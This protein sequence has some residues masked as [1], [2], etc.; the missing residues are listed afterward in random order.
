MLRSAVAFS[1]GTSKRPSTI[2]P[3]P[4]KPPRRKGLPR[5][6]TTAR[7][8]ESG[9]GRPPARGQALLGTGRSVAHRRGHARP[10]PISPLFRPGRGQQPVSRC[11]AGRFSDYL[12]IDYKDLAVDAHRKMIDQRRLEMTR[13]LDEGC[14]QGGLT[15][16]F[17]D[18]YR[19]EITYEW[20]KLVVS[21][22]TN[23]MF[24]NGKRDEGIPAVPAGYYDVLDQVELVD[25][26]AIGT[27][28]Y[29]RFLERNF[30][31]IFFAY[32]KKG[33]ISPTLSRCPL[34]NPRPLQKPTPTTIRPSRP[35]TAKSC[36]SFL[37]GNHRRLP[38]GPF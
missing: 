10:A 15:P 28:H 8:S 3:L 14:A 2:S 7:R 30:S 27:T 1:V 29:R 38:T 13:F 11:P 25:E 20:A 33:G 23:Y 5:G 32:G 35:C 16:A 12:R 19:A 22:P 18:Y 21:Y 24:A 17:V 9:L 6:R 36:T 4:S 26:A 37:P 31:A 34:R